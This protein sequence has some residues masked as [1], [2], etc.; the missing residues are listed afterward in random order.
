MS[1]TLHQAH[2]WADSCRK[3]VI[4]CEQQL[5]QAKQQLQKALDRLAELE[6][7]GADR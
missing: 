1:D 4:T 6:T 2:I 3:F 7:M 5:A